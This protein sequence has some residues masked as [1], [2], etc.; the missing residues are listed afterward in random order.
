MDDIGVKGLRT[1]YNDEEAAFGIRR[2]ML[3]YIMWLN[4]VLADLER[5]G[6]II[7]GPKSQ[8]CMPRIRIVSFVCDYLEK[9]PNFAKVIK[10]IEW[11]ESLDVS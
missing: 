5:A 10:I 6:C 11:A 2:Y 4:D 3:E 7:L 1:I 9:H 8:F